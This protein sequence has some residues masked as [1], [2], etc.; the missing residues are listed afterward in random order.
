M[1]YN[2]LYIFIIG[3]VTSG[4]GKGI[5][6]AS[7]GRIFKAFNYKVKL[8]KLDPYLNIDPGTMNPAEHGEV[9]VTYDGLETDLDVGHYER[10]LEEELHGETSIIT[11]GK[12]YSKVFENE[13][14]GKYLGK[15][16]Q[17]VPHVS[18]EVIDFI[19]KEDDKY[20]IIITEIGGTV[21]DIEGGIYYEAIRQMKNKANC[22]PILIGLVPYI[23]GSNEFK[24]KPLTNAAKDLRTLGIQPKL[25]VYRIQHGL[26]K[27]IPVPTGDIKRKLALFSDV[28]ET[29]IIPAYDRT[30]IYNIPQMLFENGIYDSLTKYG[31]EVIIIEDEFNKYY[32]ICKI[33]FHGIFNK[34]LISCNKKIAIVGKYIG[35]D[36]AYLSIIE[37]LKHSFYN[38][39]SEASIDIV[40]SDKDFDLE[41]YNGYIVPGG[42]GSRGIEGKLRAIT[43]SRKHNIPFL[44]ICLGLQLA[45]IEYFDSLGIKV[46]SKEFN[47]EQDDRLCIINDIFGDNEYHQVG[48]TMRLG[49]YTAYSYGSY[50]NSKIGN[51]Y[52]QRR[53]S[54][55]IGRHRHRFEIQIDE[56]SRFDSQMLEFLKNDYN[57]ASLKISLVDKKG[58]LC[59]AIEYTN[60]PYFIAVQWHPELDSRPSDPNPLFLEFV[61]TIIL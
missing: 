5:L 47:P 52:Y 16:V 39:G 44:G 50:L 45:V 40:D 35:N 20:E 18:N 24:T 57:E 4:I 36:D 15:T 41:K 42:F 17:L 19:T 55:P 23:S 3:G 1:K 7:I 14:N 31:S 22:I 38:L 34:T 12:I 61:K 53:K 49:N 26:E 11:S 60:H 29:D 30:N 27:T 46:Y 43:Y 32:D 2:S 48:G 10:F 37:A 21:G 59:E 28:E 6:G 13:R 8:Q 54:L 56:N 51:I 25:I 58:K 9:Y 33:S